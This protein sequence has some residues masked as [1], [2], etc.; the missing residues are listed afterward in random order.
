MGLGPLGIDVEILVELSPV[1]LQSLV[2][3]G[4]A[5][6]QP[7]DLP[8]IAADVGRESC[9]REC[10]ADGGELGFQFAFYVLGNPH[11]LDEA[12]VVLFVVE[13]EHH[14]HRH[15]RPK[16]LFEPTVVGDDLGIRREELHQLHRGLHPRNTEGEEDHHHQAGSRNYKV[17]PNDH[18]AYRPPKADEDVV[19]LAD[20]FLAGMLLGVLPRGEVVQQ[21]RQV[22]EQQVKRGN[23][24]QG[25]EDAELA[26]RDDLACHQ[27]AEPQ[28]GGQ[29]GDHAWVE[30]AAD[31]PVR[32]TLETIFLD[33]VVVVVH[34]V[35]GAGD[36]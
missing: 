12:V 27:R 8:P 15:Q 2:E 14:F 24:S 23:H 36:R 30:G 19:V 11:P 20:V 17:V 10:T 4:V 18:S 5:D 21:R 22:Q 34:Y 13:P 16:V 35:H 6:I 9:G 28:G 3:D 33:R 29:G 7:A 31:R 25:R 26:D 1:R 32:R